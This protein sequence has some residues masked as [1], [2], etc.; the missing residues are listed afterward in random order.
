MKNQK[1]VLLLHD[2]AHPHIAF[3]TRATLVKFGWELL[4]HPPYSPDLAP[5]DFHLFRSLQHHLDDKTFEN[6]KEV[7]Q[8]L[9]KFFKSKSPAFYHDGIHALP[10]RWS[11]V[12][13]NEGQYILD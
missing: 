13:D 1:G 4:P 9:K 12:L 7:N 3:L 5:T 6:K 11:E 10:K 8:E 2:I